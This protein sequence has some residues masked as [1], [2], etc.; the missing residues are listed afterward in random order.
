MGPISTYKGLKDVYHLIQ[1]MHKQEGSGGTGGP[2]PMDDIG[3]FIEMGQEQRGKPEQAMLDATMYS[4]GVMSP[5]LEHVGDLTHRMT[6]HLDSPRG[7]YIGRNEV[8]SKTE[9]SLNRLRHEYGF[10]R[11]HG[12]NLKNNARMREK[13][14]EKF[15]K[16]YNEKLKKYSEEHSKLPV[17]NRVQWLGRESAVAV[18]D[19]KFEK[20]IEYLDELNT[21]AK[22]EQGWEKMA[23]EYDPKY[24]AMNILKALKKAEK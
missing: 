7:A 8:L 18:G 19:S 1:A 13:D 9:K 23:R 15:K 10:E 3:A 22:D 21:L 17:Y 4:S 16:K 12:E 6:Q 14:Y 24:G 20:A 11:E 5:V 2:L